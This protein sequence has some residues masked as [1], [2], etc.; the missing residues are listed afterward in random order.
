M[1]EVKY[2][3]SRIENNQTIYNLR[4]KVFQQKKEA[5]S[6]MEQIGRRLVRY[7]N[8]AHIRKDPP[9]LNLYDSAPD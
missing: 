9:V 1:F 2:L 8:T 7:R 5:H 4:T 3:E 6:F